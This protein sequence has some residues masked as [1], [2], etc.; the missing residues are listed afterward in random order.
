MG[1]FKSLRVRLRTLEAAEELEAS[2]RRRRP[3]FEGRK[4]DD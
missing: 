3:G 1:H 2:Q 4:F